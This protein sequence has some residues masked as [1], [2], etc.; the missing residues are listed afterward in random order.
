MSFS[1]FMLYNHH[2]NPIQSFFFAFLKFIA[3]L[4]ALM[5]LTI[6]AALFHLA[7][8]SGAFLTLLKTLAHWQQGI[9]WRDAEQ[10]M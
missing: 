3:G 10:F 1:K 6:K 8:S 5:S 4:T 9:P 7:I 2:H